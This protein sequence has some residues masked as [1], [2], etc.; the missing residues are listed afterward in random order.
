MIGNTK[1]SFQLSEP[2]LGSGFER[3]GPHELLKN[4]HRKTVLKGHGFTS[5]EKHSLQNCF[6]RARLYEW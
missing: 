5:G 2:M 3:A 1:G 6:E 4:S